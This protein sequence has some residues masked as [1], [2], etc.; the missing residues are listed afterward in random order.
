MSYPSAFSRR[1]LRQQRW[2][3]KRN[4]SDR[5]LRVALSTLRIQLHLE[6]PDHPG[7]NDLD[8]IV[9]KPPT[10]ISVKDP[11]TALQKTD[12]SLLANATPRADGKG[13]EDALGVS[14]ESAVV[15]PS[16]WKELAGAQEVDVA[17][18]RAPVVDVDGG[19]LPKSDVMSALPSP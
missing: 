12:D 5:F 17:A 13:L 10:G 6:S 19:L 9:R 7:Q 18:E 14:V 8:A 3:L 4:K 16:F 11:A 1:Q 2:S 15:Q